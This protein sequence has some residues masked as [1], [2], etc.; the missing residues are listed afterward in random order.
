MAAGSASIISQVRQLLAGSLTLMQTL[1][2]LTGAELRANAGA[3]RGP[4]AAL[5]AAAALGGTALALLLVAA[6][7]ALAHYVGPLGATLIVAALAAVTALALARHGLSR[8]GQVRL[9][10]TRAI[11]TLQLQIDRFS[12]KPVKDKPNEQ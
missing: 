3:L 7:L 11:A 10:P 6:I 2:K 8:L 4:L 12:A 5:L 1:L 9:A